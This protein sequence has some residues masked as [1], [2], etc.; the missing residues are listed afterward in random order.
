MDSTTKE[1]SCIGTLITQEDAVMPFYKSLDYEKLDFSLDSLNLLDD[2]LEMVRKN[3]KKLTQ[4]QLMRVI[5]RCGS[6]LGEVIR[7][8]DSKKFRW[9]TYDQAYKIADKDRKKYLDYLGKDITTN[10]ILYDSKSKTF[11]F[12]LAKPFKFLENGRGDSLIGLA[13]FCLNKI[14]GDKAFKIRNLKIPYRQ[15]HSIKK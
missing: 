2:Y 9:I 4:E 8:T 15:K 1:V 5:I 14:K 10:F 6:Y 3:K 13:M 12:T 7:K 11:N